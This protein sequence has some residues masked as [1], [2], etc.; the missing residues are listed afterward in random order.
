MFINLPDLNGTTPL[1]E[2]IKNGRDG[3]A[4]ALVL[5]EAHLGIDDVGEYLCKMVSE[6]NL[7]FLRTLRKYNI[8]PNA[9]NYA[10]Q[11][12]LHIAA[13]KGSYSAAEELLSAGADRNLKDRY[14]FYL[15]F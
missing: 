1:L 10:G 4:E 11:T 7:Y 15:S 14:M 8:D 6:Q 3:V 9:K 2:A 5:A 12:A 13:A